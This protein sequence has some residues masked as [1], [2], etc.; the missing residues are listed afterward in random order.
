LGLAPRSSLPL[1][2]QHIPDRDRSVIIRG[3]QPSPRDEFIPPPALLLVIVGPLG[4]G[5][6]HGRMSVLYGPT[7]TNKFN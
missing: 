1:F 2:N 6:L 4:R 5:G 7:V 3:I